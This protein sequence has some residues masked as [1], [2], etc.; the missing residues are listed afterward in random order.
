MKLTKKEYMEIIGWYAK[1]M[2]YESK[3]TEETNSQT[4]TTPEAQ[5]A[6]EKLRFSLEDS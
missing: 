1:K 5:T 3:H 6:L 2:Y 4:S